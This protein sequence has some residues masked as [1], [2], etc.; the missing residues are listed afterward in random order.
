MNE[1]LDGVWLITAGYLYGQHRAA[2][3]PVAETAQREED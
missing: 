1:F 2:P 3:P